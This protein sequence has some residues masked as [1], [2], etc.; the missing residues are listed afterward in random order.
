MALVFPLA[1]PYRESPHLDTH[2][3]KLIITNAADDKRMVF[4]LDRGVCSNIRL[5]Y[6]KT[7]AG[8]E[9]PLSY[10]SNPTQLSPLLASVPPQ[11]NRLKLR[12]AVPPNA[13]TLDNSLVILKTWGS[14]TDED[15]LRQFVHLKQYDTPSRNVSTIAFSKLGLSDNQVIVNDTFVPLGPLPGN[16]NVY[17]W[18]LLTEGILLLFSFL[19][20]VE[21]P[22]PPVEPESP[23]DPAD[24]V[25][26]D[27]PLGAFPHSSQFSVAKLRKAFSFSLDDG[28]EYRLAL[29][30][31]EDSVP[32]LKR[33]LSTLME[34]AKTID[35]TVRRLL[36]SRARILECIRILE[37]NTFNSLPKELGLYEAFAEMFNSVFDS[38]SYNA[39]FL[40]DKVLNSASLSKMYSSCLSVMPHDGGEASMKKK[41]FEKSSKE[42]Y[43][44][45]NKYLSNEKDRPELKLL[46][47]RKN[48]ELSKFDYFNTLNSSSNNQ[49]F[50]QFVEDLFKVSKLPWKSH[51]LDVR[52]FRDTKASQR[53]LTDDM[54][55]YFF[56]LARFNS[57]KKQL[58][59]M[60]EACDTNEELTS[61]IRVN[62]LYP[63]K[64]D[65]NISETN[66]IPILDLIF[67]STISLPLTEVGHSSFDDQ[68]G[69][70]SG[71]LYA[72]GGQGKP[73]WHKEWVVLEKG[74]LMEF[75]DWRKGR[76]PINTP[77]NVA[78]AN[79][80]PMNH[81]KRQYCFEILT[82]K[83][84]KHVFQAL[85]NNERNEWIKALYN[86]GQVTLQLLKPNVRVKTELNNPPHLLSPRC[87][88]RASP[89][90]VTSSSILNLEVDFLDIVRSVEDSRND[91][92]ADCGSGDSVEWV[93]VNLMVVVCLKCSSCHR[94]MGSHVSKIRSLKLDNFTKE[95]IV[96]LGY[97][98]NV[99]VNGYL[100][101][102]AKDSKIS[103]NLTDNER[104]A[105]IKAKY[106][107]KTFAKLEPSPNLSLVSAVRKIDIPAVIRALN[108]GADPN[109]R[110][111][112]SSDKSALG[113]VV[114]LFEYSLRKLVEIKKNG[115]TKKF[116]VVSELLFLNGCNIELISEL[117]EGLEFSKEANSYWQEKRLRQG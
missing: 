110:L 78:L 100:E 72:L 97:I 28:P 69:A 59:Q 93:S 65:N 95:G 33:A 98:N 43:D 15:Q 14:D 117:Q 116:F 115:E 32:R 75:S 94:N 58:R 35:A 82:S 6:T 47:K 54:K 86:A 70:I 80:K 40:A 68:S 113:V 22:K 25:L 60:I 109:I 85:N 23:S 45:L 77:I 107:A 39:L 1:L 101:F 111:Q 10:V 29:R 3:L 36:M 16:M 64:I 27:P 9:T 73:G 104:L 91:L 42:Y 13:D 87:E 81:D 20:W 2:L 88:G 50:N 8:L 19:L 52:A 37:D 12:L 103:E 41:A 76:L 102:G 57:E 106:I 24:K 30:K 53:L 89:L 71:I 83:G 34:E 96:L 105:Y 18:K 49:Y 4:D 7:N 44:W 21:L 5:I 26:P 90:S 99:D 112:L 38:I 31:Y 55:L 62:S 17:V 48:F 51:V 46:L 114:L 108:C 61:L 11:F 66:D 56:A 84:Q 67:P 74:Q 79:V 63:G 92:C